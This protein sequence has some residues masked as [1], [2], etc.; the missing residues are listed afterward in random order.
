MFINGS[1]SFSSSSSTS[2]SIT[3]FA[4][5]ISNSSF[6]SSSSLSSPPPIP[7]LHSLPPP[8]SP[9]PPYLPS[10]LS[11][12]RLRLCSN[13]EVGGVGREGEISLVSGSA[14]TPDHQWPV[15]SFINNS[16]WHHRPPASQTTACTPT[17]HQMLC[18]GLNRVYR[19]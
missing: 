9:P 5:S 18:D 17:S 14:R 8:S 2:S 6:S 12:S 3:T 13:R 10:P 15:D 19:R 11:Q 1:S 4:T 16:P 7:P